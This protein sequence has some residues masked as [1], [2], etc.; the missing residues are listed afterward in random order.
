MKS[1]SFIPYLQSLIISYN[2][3]DADESVQLIIDILNQLVDYVEDII[4]GVYDGDKEL[5]DKTLNSLIYNGIKAHFGYLEINSIQKKLFVQ[6]D[7][8]T[9]HGCISPEKIRQLLIEKKK[10]IKEIL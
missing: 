2:F 6:W 9:S 10:L 3:V 7:T 4:I 5:S 8:R 1:T